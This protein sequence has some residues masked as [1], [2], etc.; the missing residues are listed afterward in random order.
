[1]LIKLSFLNERLLPLSHWSQTPSSRV[2]VT[3]HNNS[4][5]LGD[6][7]MIASGHDSRGH[8]S[9]GNSDGLTL[10]RH[11][12][13]LVIDVN[14]V[15]EPKQ[16]GDHQLGTVADGIHSGILDDHSLVVRKE[17]LEGHDNSA[18]VG[19]VLG[20]VIDVLGIKDVVHGN[21]I[22]RLGQDTGTDTAQLLHVSAGTNEQTKVDAHGSD[23]RSSLA[24]DPEDAQVALLVV[25]NKLGFVNGTD[26]KL[27]LHSRDEGRTLEEGTGQSF[28]GAVQLARV[29]N[30]R[31][32]TDD[33]DVLL[34][35]RLL[36]LDEAGGPVDA[37]D[38]AAGNLGI[39]RSGMSGL[40]DAQDALDPGHDLMTRGVG[41]LVQIDHTIREMRLERS[42]QGRRSGGDGGIMRGTDVK[43]IIIPKEQRPFR[44]VNLRRR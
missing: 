19:L 18:E 36:R 37:N 15:C 1:M 39:E 27:T 16:T 35:S 9:N 21:H 6:T 10:G 40:L 14:V 29:L 7:A 44:G 12:D 34:T 32:K 8:L 23:V 5:D 26:T 38:K 31:V 4:L 22:V 42:G 20:A 17:G 43:L 41:G 33:A 2:C 3:L 30:G 11:Q 28:D 24:R 13:Y 25:L